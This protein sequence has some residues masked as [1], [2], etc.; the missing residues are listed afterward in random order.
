MNQLFK[1]T[2]LAAAIAATCGTA[3]A[4]TVAV[5]KQV[6]SSEGLTGVTANQTSGAIT[7]TLGAAYK[8]GDKAVSIQ[9]I[10]KM[11]EASRTVIR[12]LTELEAEMQ[13]Q[14]HQ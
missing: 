5:T 1:T 13:I 2:L 11:E 6:H 3:V 8:E 12:M 4:G 14:D 9:H 7:Y 10:Q